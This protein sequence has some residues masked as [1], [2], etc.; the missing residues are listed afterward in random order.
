MISNPLNLILVRLNLRGGT[1]AGKNATPRLPKHCDPHAVA[2]IHI[3]ARLRKK[4]VKHT[5]HA[6]VCAPLGP[7]YK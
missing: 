2:E 3:N 6:K 7:A 5:V 4:K 1:G